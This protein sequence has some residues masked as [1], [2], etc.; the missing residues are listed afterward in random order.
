[1]NNSKIEMELE[2]LAVAKLNTWFTSRQDVRNFVD[3]V[4][5]RDGKSY[6]D[7]LTDYVQSAIDSY[8][9]LTDG[10]DA[11][12]IAT[13]AIDI[14]EAGSGSVLDNVVNLLDIENEERN[15]D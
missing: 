4:N 5:Q 9:D 3:L 15:N 11:K 6:R 14:A 8:S 10:I 13:A 2:L 12:N 1:M 7:R